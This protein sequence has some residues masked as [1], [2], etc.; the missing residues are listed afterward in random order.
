MGVTVE[1]K[2]PIEFGSE[3]ITEIVVNKPKGK[4]FRKLPVE[5]KLMDELWPFACAIC[6]QPAK[7]LDELGADDFIAVMEVVGNFMPDGLEIGGNP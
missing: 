3:T 5:P 7:V 4:H 2:E 6:N 1:L